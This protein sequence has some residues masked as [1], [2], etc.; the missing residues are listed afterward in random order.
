MRRRGAGRRRG[1]QSQGRRREELLHRSRSPGSRAPTYARPEACATTGSMR[2]HSCTQQVIRRVHMVAQQTENV[3]PCGRIL[4]EHAE[5]RVFID[6]PQFTCRAGPG[7]VVV[8]AAGDNGAKA[9]NLARVSFAQISQFARSPPVEKIDFAGVED[10]NAV[11]LFPFVE[12][13]RAGLHMLPPLMLRQSI[14][15]QRTSRCQ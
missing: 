1:V 6:E 8:S 15:E 13:D 9:E 2:D 11:W 10:I 7:R 5:E 4:L 14:V 3:E 12:E